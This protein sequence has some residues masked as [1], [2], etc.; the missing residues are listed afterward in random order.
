MNSIEFLDCASERE[1]SVR[2]GV[3]V[4]EM[5]HQLQAQVTDVRIVA[6]RSYGRIYLRWKSNQLN[7]IVA[8][9]KNIIDPSDNRVTL[10]MAELQ[11][12]IDTINA[13]I[14]L[15]RKKKRT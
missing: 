9:Y 4:D 10:L 1:V 3:M 7:K 2:V 13:H 11:G 6:H 12:M 8:N 14:A 15:Q 5:N